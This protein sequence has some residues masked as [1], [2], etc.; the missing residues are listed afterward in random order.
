[1]HRFLQVADQERVGDTEPLRR[2]EID[3]NVAMQ[4]A[5]SG[6]VGFGEEEGMG[7]IATMTVK[8]KVLLWDQGSIKQT[9]RDKLYPVAKIIFNSDEE[10]RFDG[11]ICKV[12]MDNVKFEENFNHMTLSQKENHKRGLWA[13]WSTMVSKGLDSKRHNQKTTLRDVFWGECK[14]TIALVLR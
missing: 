8:E 1:V 3:T 7:R 5:T 12:I 4:N 2:G 10:L 9:I 13:V 14:L 6:T 11:P